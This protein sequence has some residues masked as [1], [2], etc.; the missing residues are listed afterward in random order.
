MGPGAGGAGGGG[1]GIQVAVRPPISRVVQGTI[2]AGGPILDST[3]RGFLGAFP[4]VLNAGCRLMT[5]CDVAAPPSGRISRGTG[6]QPVDRRHFHPTT[7]ALGKSRFQ[8]S[9]F[10]SAA[11]CGQAMHSVHGLK[12]RA[13]KNDLHN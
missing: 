1:G 13:T 9:V 12:S 7:R 6:F 11:P 10:P 4:I 8:Y 3:A 5:L 2:V